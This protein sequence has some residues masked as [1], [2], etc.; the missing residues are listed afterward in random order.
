[1]KALKIL[2]ITSLFYGAS[3]YA[4]DEQQVKQAIDDAKQ[5]FNKA[6]EQQGGWMSTKKLLKN[7]EL[8]SA[9]GDQKKA[10]ELAQKAKREAEIS[11]AQILEQDKNW[12]EPSYLSK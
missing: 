7:A 11:Y 1:M 2:A 6:V 4:L 8:S 10:Y 9:K 5:A 3:V 12:S